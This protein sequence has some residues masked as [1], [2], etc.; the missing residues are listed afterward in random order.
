MTATIDGYHIDYKITG[1]EGR[2]V[3][4]ILQGW[5]THYDLY[6]SIAALLAPTH[7]VVQFDLPGFGNSDEPREG[8]NVDAYTDFFLRFLAELGITEAMLIGH[9][10][11][12]R[13]ILKLT[14]RKELPLTITDIILI[15]AAGVRTPK[16]RAQLRR[17]RRYK[18]LK[19]FFGLKP[20]YAAFKDIVDLWRSGQGSEDYRNA[21]EVMKKCLV[22]AVNE[23]L[24][25]LLPGITQD[26]LLIWGDRDTATPIEHAHIM[27]AK[28]PKNGL[29]VIPGVGHFSFLEAPAAF[30]GIMKAYLGSQGG[31]Q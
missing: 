18:R 30:A 3:A 23:D 13:I 29:A 14:G 25:G 8:W 24:T 2:P 7:R 27:E 9:S 6:D 5:G 4:V 28:I 26:V 15:D 20:V 16:S 17:E 21:S 22:M 10:Y 11:G 19:W 1:E 31:A 12:G